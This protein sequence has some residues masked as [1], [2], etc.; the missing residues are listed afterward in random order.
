MPLP[1]IT[2]PECGAGL[3]SASGFNAGQSV[4]CPKCETY[5][6]V[7]EPEEEDRPRRKVRTSATDDDDEDDRPKR[8]KKK[9]HDEE[10]ERSYRN[11]PLRYAVLAVLVIVMLVLGYLLYQKRQREAE[12][13][14]PARSD[15]VRVLV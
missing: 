2:C 3:K 13:W 9:R 10:D 5:F 6:A 15:C 1:R 11:S 4:M 8:R 7:E 14:N 12:A